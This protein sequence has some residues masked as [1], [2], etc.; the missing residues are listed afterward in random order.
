MRRREFITLLA[1]AGW[2]LA[3]RAQQPAMPVIGF[4]HS[5]SPE[6]VAHI[7]AG[8]HRGLG[9][10]GYFVGGNLAIEYLW[11]RG[12][13]DQLPLLAADLV[14]RGCSVI[15]AA[16]GEH[17]ARAAKAA[18][19]TI[20]VVFTVAGDPVNAGLV[21]SLNKPAG[22]LTGT[23]SFTSVVETKKFG[24]LREMVPH[25]A[26]IAM[27]INP[28]FPPAEPDAKDVHVAAQ[29]LG[30]QLIIVRASNEQ[31]ID[32]AFARIGE[33]QANALL[34]AGDPFFN[35]RREQIVGLAGHRSLPG[36]YE[37]REYVVAGGLMS[38]GISLPDNYRQMGIYVGRILKGAKVFELPI[39]QP[40][41]F[42]FAI[43]LKAATS[44]GL[45]VPPSLLA[46][47]D[48]VIE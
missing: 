13:Y 36:I 45:I 41:R 29:S 43:N 47:A 17:T 10:T 33:M 8:F 26:A 21:A 34:V 2:P 3:A 12:R 28:N 15:V 35:S 30:H 37:F 18:T 6:Q 31:E 27:L 39:M 20:P 46:L 38:Y 14:Q 1:V 11:A 4:L 44:L 22:N 25:A 40:T 7:L 42:E 16:G 24:L 19:S 48:E 32:A 23:V 9:E 5:G